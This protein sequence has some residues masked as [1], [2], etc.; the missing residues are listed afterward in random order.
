VL[1]TVAHFSDPQSAELIGLMGIDCLW[2]DLEHQPLGVSEFEEMARAA[3]V[4]DMDVMA[5]A[6]KGEF[7]RA[8]RLL[9]A[10]TTLLMYPRC[11]SEAEARSLVL[12]A[13]FPP[14]GERGFFSASPDNPYTLTPP[15]EYIRIANEQTVLLAQIESPAAVKQA[16]AIAG[17]DGIDMLFFGPGDFSVLAG[18]PGEFEHPTVRA[19]MAETAGYAREAGKR[20]GTLVGTIDQAKRALDLGA[21]LLAYGSDLTFARGAL[22]QMKTNFSGLGF[23]F[24]PTRHGPVGHA[25]LV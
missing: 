8:A 22:Q 12:A 25:S 4:S 20:F 5:R 23:E 3:R 14:L 7:L 6:A 24:G 21:S 16:H 18:V 19:A 17:V 15:T 10:G 2:V 13:K 11:E 9:E 1:A